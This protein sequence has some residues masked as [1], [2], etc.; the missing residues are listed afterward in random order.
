MNINVIGGAVRSLLCAVYLLGC[1]L[2]P[3]GQTAAA[4]ERSALREKDVRRAERVLE[5]LRLLGNAA[6]AQEGGDGFRDLARKSYP[7]LFV[8]VADMRQSD[9]KT[10]LGTAVFLYEDVSRAWTAVGNSTAYC[11]GERP[12]VYRPLC[13]RLGGGTARHLLLAK[14]RLHFRWAEAVVKTY[15]GGGDAETSRLLSEMKAAREHDLL[16][17]ARVSETLKSLEG[18]VNTSST[19]ADYLEHRVAAKVS[20]ETLETEFS[21]AL[22]RAGALL[23]WMPRSPVYYCLSSAW[24]SYRD[25]LFWYRKVHSSKKMVVSAAAGFGRDPLKELRLDAEQVG[26]TVVTNWKAAAKYTRLAEQSLSG[27]AR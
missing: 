19:Y 17:A 12:D 7:G 16:I 25:G 10:D 3:H 5:R 20:F 21:D 27:A 4:G 2:T 24:R 26:Y 14:A 23:G 18:M 9:L 6:A 15:R 13:L 22:G 8:T 1:A 11:E